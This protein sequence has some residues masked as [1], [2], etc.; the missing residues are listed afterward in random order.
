MSGTVPTRAVRNHTS[1]E[2]EADET[3]SAAL[4]QHF[5]FF[6]LRPSFSLHRLAAYFSLFSFIFS[7]LSKDESGLFKSPA[8]LCVPTNN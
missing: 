3:S 2:I 8:C 5:R 7:L 1:P 4:Q 6:S